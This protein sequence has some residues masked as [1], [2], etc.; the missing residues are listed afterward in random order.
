MVLYAA[1]NTSVWLCVWR[2]CR[3]YDMRYMS[4]HPA[5]LYAASTASTMSNNIEQAKCETAVIAQN[6]SHLIKFNRF[7][8][9]QMC[10]FTLLCCLC[11]CLCMC[12][13]RAR[14]RHTSHIDNW[15]NPKFF[16][17]TVIIICVEL[18][19]FPAN[20][21]TVWFW[22]LVLFLLWLSYCKIAATS[23]NS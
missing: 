16:R 17:L 13:G 12:C 1:W 19:R 20:L 9:I 7:N 15:R 21:F 6:N 14:L 23:D 4:G 10:V 3:T 22:L 8:G 5:T 2:W 18:S 11:V